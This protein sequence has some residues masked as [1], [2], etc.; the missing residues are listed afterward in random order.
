M[1][2]LIC[3]VL[4]TL[5]TVPLFLSLVSA[6]E[7]QASASEVSAARTVWENAWTL[8]SFHQDGKINSTFFSCPKVI[9]NGSHWVDYIFNSS[10]MSGGIGS[11]CVKFRPTYATIYD[12][13]RT[14]VRIQDER[15]MAEW[16]DES[17]KVWKRDR[18]LVT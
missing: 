4:I 6:S 15:W 14:E 10:D 11:V 1:K 7:V 17:I 5:V 12:P 3:M 13:K 2:R 16:Y 18:V 8:T 9:W